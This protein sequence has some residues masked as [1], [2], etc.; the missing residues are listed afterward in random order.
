MSLLNGIRAFWKLEEAASPSV[1]ATGRGNDLTW[2]GGAARATGI[3]GYGLD[4]DLGGD[5][6]YHA[7]NDDL[8]PGIRDDFTLAGWFKADSDWISQAGYNTICALPGVYRVEMSITGGTHVRFTCYHAT[9]SVT[10]EVDGDPG[11][12]WFFYR[13]WRDANTINL[14]IDCGTAQSAAFDYD[15]R[16]VGILSFYLGGGDDGG[17]YSYTNGTHENPGLWA[18]VLENYESDQLCTGV[19]YPFGLCGYLAFGSYEFP[20]TFHAADD[21]LDWLIPSIKAA[22][23]HGGHSL[24]ATLREKRITVRGGIIKGPF[25]RDITLREELDALRAA[26][27]LQPQNLYFEPD[28]YWRN[29]R[30]E[31]FRNPYGPTHYCRI[32]EGVEILFVTEDPF[33][34]AVDESSD[35]WAA[36]TTGT[37]RA[38]SV[39][40]NAPSQPTFAVT[41]GGSGS[42][43]IAFTIENETTG[44]SFTLTG[45]ALGG[46][47]ITVNTLAQTVMIG[48]VDEIDLFDGQF[49]QF[50][51]DTDNTLQVTITSGSITSIV[52]TWRNRWY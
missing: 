1:D 33:Q 8:A 2:A 21:N 52:T 50:T 25:N 49:P 14:Q 5:Y 36:P 47:V 40:G 23:R 29:V 19:E 17:T 46:E 27:A 26:L 34:Y 16:Q 18:R 10:V 22:R 28:R 30:V 44:E 7:S 12:D 35:T 37:T 4:C 43:T 41:V 32:A 15:I 38:V 20:N 24:A 3:I 45:T 39:G 6:A 42:Q 51:A 9:G 11:T 48:A 13:A 31:M